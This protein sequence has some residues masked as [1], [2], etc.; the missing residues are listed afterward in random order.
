MI[1][2]IIKNAGQV[3]TCA[4]EGLA[5]PFAGQEADTLGI[6]TGVVNNIMQTLAWRPLIII[7]FIV[8][9]S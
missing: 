4:K 6:T 3:L 2:L 1:D 9:S 7:T 8:S 5:P